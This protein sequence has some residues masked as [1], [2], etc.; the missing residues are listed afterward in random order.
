MERVLS[1]SF[2]DDDDDDATPGRGASARKEAD[3]P[4]VFRYAG[5]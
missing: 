3:G 1:A 4:D 5:V 2:D